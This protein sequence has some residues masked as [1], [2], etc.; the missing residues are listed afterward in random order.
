M[1]TQCPI[2]YV[3]PTFALQITEVYIHSAMIQSLDFLFSPP[4][5]V[6]AIVVLGQATQ[7][8]SAVTHEEMGVRCAH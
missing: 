4:G 8:V 5:L 1:D 2:I 3:K 7:V 6:I